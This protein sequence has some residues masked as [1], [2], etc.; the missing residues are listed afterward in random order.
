MGPIAPERCDCV[1][2]VQSALASEPHSPQCS[3]VHETAVQYTAIEVELFTA[4]TLYIGRLSL[5]AYRFT[6]GYTY[7]WRVHPLIVRNPIILQG[8]CKF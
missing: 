4:V 1:H 7:V 3:A 2:V 6:S 8:F 5:H